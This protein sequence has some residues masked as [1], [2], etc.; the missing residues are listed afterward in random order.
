MIG[1]TVHEIARITNLSVPAVKMR[2]SRSQ[3]KPV[4]MEARYAIDDLDGIW[5]DTIRKAPRR[6]INRE[7]DDSAKKVP[8]VAE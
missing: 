6:K 3:I 2:L 1:L 7:I 4:S 5:G 8:V